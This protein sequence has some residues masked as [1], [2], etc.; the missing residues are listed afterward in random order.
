MPRLE[1]TNIKTCNTK[2]IVLYLFLSN[3]LSFKKN[4]K[5]KDKFKIPVEIL[6]N[7]GLKVLILLVLAVVILR[8]DFVFSVNLTS[9]RYQQ[10]Q[11]QRMPT[12]APSQSIEKKENKITDKT[13]PLSSNENKSSVIISTE[14]K[15]EP[16]MVMLNKVDKKIRVAY[17]KRFAHVAVDEMKKY[18]IPASITLAQAMLHSAAGSSAQAFHGHN[19]FN[20]ECGNWSGETMNFATGECYRKYQSAWRGFRNH[21][22]HITTGAYSELKSLSSTDYKGWA[23]ALAKKGYSSEKSYKKDL[24]SLVK[25]YNLNR[26]DY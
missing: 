2:Q 23:D 14:G 15:N 1:I 7:N 21:S 4:M 26:Y 12:P 17:I 5:G 25:K 16:A 22:E 24:L 8:K 9:P 11:E 18:G 6:R 20:L 19:H 13:S 3:T 10:Q